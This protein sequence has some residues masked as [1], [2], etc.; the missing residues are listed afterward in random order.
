[1]PSRRRLVLIGLLAVAYL[2]FLYWFGGRGRPLSSA[3][4][5]TFLARIQAS[6]RAEAHPELVPNLKALASKDDGKPFFMVNLERF[7]R[8]PTPKTKT[9]SYTSAILPALLR[10]ACF[11]VYVGTVR[12]PLLGHANTG[13]TRVAIV[14][15]R[16]I[17]DFFQ[18]FT[19]PGIDL[20]LGHKFAALSETNVIAT[21]PMIALVPI[22]SLVGFLFLLVGTLLWYVRRPGAS[23]REKGA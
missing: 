23:E 2:A 12:G 15:Y 21:N 5:S 14:R 6:P 10:R 3:E 11:P 8:V 16:S 13:V 18:I 7:D 20:S 19:T 9:S 17:R 22:R 1:M 4:A